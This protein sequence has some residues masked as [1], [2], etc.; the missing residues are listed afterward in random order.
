MVPTEQGVH[1]VYHQGLHCKNRGAQTF[2]P[3]RAK[4]ETYCWAAGE[5]QIYGGTFTPVKEVINE[6]WKFNPDEKKRFP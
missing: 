2:L 5:K 6:N 1:M 3:S 4:T